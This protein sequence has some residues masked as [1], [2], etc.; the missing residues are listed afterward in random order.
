MWSERFA[1]LFITK[2]VKDQ[3]ALKKASVSR[4]DYVYVTEY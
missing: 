3:R 4:T 2:L 1:E